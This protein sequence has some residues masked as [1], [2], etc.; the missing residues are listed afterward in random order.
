MGRPVSVHNGG[1]LAKFLV[2]E[3]MH[4]NA[5]SSNKNRHNEGTE[6]GSAMPQRSRK[7]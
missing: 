2:G 4:S 1:N 6:I 5:G 3:K 7:E